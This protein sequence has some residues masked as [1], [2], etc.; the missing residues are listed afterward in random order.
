[1]VALALHVFHE[2]SNSGLRAMVCLLLFSF[3]SNNYLMRSSVIWR[4]MKLSQG[5]CEEDGGYHHLVDVMLS[6]RNWENELILSWFPSLSVCYLA[7]V[8]HT[9]IHAYKSASIHTY[10]YTLFFYKNMY[11]IRWSRLK[12][13]KFYLKFLRINPRLRFWKGYNFVCSKT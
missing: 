1:M 11:F 4:I 13:A 10:M 2:Q 12:F 8:I 7:D 5:R 6:S 9:N 3:L